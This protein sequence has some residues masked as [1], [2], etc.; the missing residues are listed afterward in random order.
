M[1]DKDLQKL[2]SRLNRENDNIKVHKI[3]KTDTGFSLYMDP[4]KSHPA[5]SEDASV[6]YRA[7]I[8]RSVL[9]LV[10]PAVTTQTPQ[11]LFQRSIDYYYNHGLY[12]TIVDLLVNFSAKGF[13][14]DIDDPDIKYFYDSWN[15]QVNFKKVVRWIFQD[16]FRVGLVRTYKVLGKY[17][18]PVS[19]LKPPESTALD[20]SPETSARKKKWSSSHVPVK[21]TVLN[22]LLVNIEGS[23]LFDMTKVTLSPSSEL[24]ALLRKKDKELTQEEKDLIKLLP[25]EFKNAVM[26]GKN[27]LLDQESVGV[28]DYRRLPYERYP[29]PR[30]ARSFDSLDYQTKLREADV[31]T[32]D[33]ISNYILKITIGNDEYPCTSQ[34][35]LS[36]I[37]NLFNTPSKSF[38]VVWNHTLNIEKIVSPEIEAVLGQDKYKQVNEDLTGAFGVIRALID[39]VGQGLS[40]NGI[41]LATKSVIEEINYARDEVSDW[42]YH[43]Y[44]EVAESTGFD[45]YPRVRWDDMTLKDEIMMTSLI[46]G[47]I[48]RRIISYQTG[49]EKLGLNFDTEVAQL[50]SEKPLV[51]NGDLGLW[52]SPYNPKAAPFV[53]T[54][55]TV[56]PDK[57]QNTPDGTP[58]DGRPRAKPGKK[59]TKAPPQDKT[60]VPLAA[61]LI[62]EL[63][64]RFLSKGISE[65][66]ISDIINSILENR[67]E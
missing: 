56:S 31:S 43:E 40:A 17:D 11:Q 35:E 15:I 5:W 50:A 59:K 3:E 58:S 24:K 10:K 14:N 33:G 47:M 46:Q 36:K 52:G 34:D 41:A 61:G 28:V 21:Y 57:V 62:K 53:P 29:R 64:A 65:D 22:P 13:E 54:D 2:V 39:G 45:R 42:I 63:S 7:P 19:Y 9:H 32:L 27:I 6:I 26:S 25:Q 20:V 23:L 44:R 8:D 37:A 16:F 4:P 55:T 60:K 51:L 67:S 12:G 30:G 49:H 1:I 18:P 48:D 66:E 38:N